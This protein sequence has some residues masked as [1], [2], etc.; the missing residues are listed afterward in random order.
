MSA[1]PFAFL[2]EGRSEVMS[3]SEAAETAVLRQG[4]K[5]LGRREIRLDPEDVTVLKL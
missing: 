5:E 2:N 4:E 3:V 1:F